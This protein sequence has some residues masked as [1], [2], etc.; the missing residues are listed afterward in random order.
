MDLTQPIRSVIPSAQGHV[1]AILARTDRPL[2]GRGVAELTD[3]RLSAK[4]V[5][6][7]L[8]AL[9][10]HGLVLVEDHPPAKLYTLNRRHLAAGAIVELAGLRTRLIASLRHGF[11]TWATPA[12]GAWLFGS[13]ARGDGTADSD[14]D[15][16]LVR[17]DDIDIEDA[18]WT[19]QVDEL[20][21]DV[22]AWTGNPCAVIEYSEGEF[23][24]LM[25]AEG[26]LVD[27]LRSD[28]LALLDATALPEPAA[29]G[30]Q[31]RR[32]RA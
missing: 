25:A 24:D 18:V 15:L 2:S 9:A 17:K 32:S 21:D 5:N 22:R 4:G 7:A 3:G 31:R 19:A 12:A 26:Q 29:P 16:L 23:A 11:T 10:A 27:E 20:V 30:H 13:A 6:L 8:R 1:L 14:I 28:A